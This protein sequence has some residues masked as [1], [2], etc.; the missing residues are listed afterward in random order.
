MKGVYRATE[1]L[2]D[3]NT[4][5][6]EDVVALATTTTGDLATSATGIESTI[7]ALVPVIKGGE[8]VD[9]YNIN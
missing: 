6:K 9:G 7:A 1:Y 3:I 4:L 2:Y 8:G 5:N